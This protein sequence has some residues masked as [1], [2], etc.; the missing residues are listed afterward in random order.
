[1]SPTVRALRQTWLTPSGKAGLL[2]TDRNKHLLD[3]DQKAAWKDAMLNMKDS[4]GRCNKIHF[5]L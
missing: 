5:Y 3:D 4:S 1:M 2:V